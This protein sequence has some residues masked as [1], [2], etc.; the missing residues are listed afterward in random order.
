MDPFSAQP[1]RRVASR[2]ATRLTRCSV[3]MLVKPL[4]Q[5]PRPEPAPLRGENRRSGVGSLSESM[6]SH[7]WH[8]HRGSERPPSS[9]AAADEQ[10]RRLSEWP[11]NNSVQPPPLRFGDATRPWRTTRTPARYAHRPDPAPPGTARQG[12]CAVLGRCVLREAVSP[13]RAHPQSATG[14]AM[15]P[16]GASPEG[17]NAVLGLR[18]TRLACGKL[19][20]DWP[21]RMRENGWTLGGAGG[22]LPPKSARLVALRQ[23]G[24]AGSVPARTMEQEQRR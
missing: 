24:Y 23:L 17:A 4:G 2:W 1:R 10:R 14:R 11:P 3:A 8:V 16:R 19:E 6:L 7:P 5:S 15:R 12:R 21:A 13:S 18:L 22:Q 20:G 9:S